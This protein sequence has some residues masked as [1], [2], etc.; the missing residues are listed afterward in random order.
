MTR[1][2]RGTA[3]LLGCGVVIG[4]LR[5]ASGS[6]VAGVVLFLLFAVLA[7]VG[8]PGAFPRPVSDAVA[9]ERSAADG[10]P[11]V[12]WRPGCP[13]CIRLRTRLGREARRA[14]W[15]DIWA[16]PEGAATVRAATGGDETVP[17]V[18]H[19]GQAHINPDPRRV[20]EM[21]RR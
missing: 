1:R 15:V 18:V 13:F 4:A 6:V 17:T 21:V 8:S 19:G 11:I 3:V 12:Y 16:D 20:R 7:V 14:H 2:W 9:R 5:V 10:R